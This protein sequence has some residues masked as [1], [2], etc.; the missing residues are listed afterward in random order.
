[1]DDD[2]IY[3]PILNTNLV[4]SITQNT[5][6][7]G[8]NIIHD[9]DLEVIARGV[10]WSTD[11]VPTID[12]NDGMTVDGDGIGIFVSHI[13]GLTEDTQ[14]FICS[15]ATNSE[16][17][18][19]GQV[20]SFVTPALSVPELTTK[21]PIV[22]TLNSATSG[23]YV[24]SSGGMEMFSIGIVW[25]TSGNPTVDSNEGITSNGTELGGFLCEMTGL[26]P[27]THYYIRAYATN[28]YGTGYGNEVSLFI[29]EHA[30]PFL[31]SFVD[32]RDGN[33]YNTVL[34]D[35]ECWMAENLKYLP[36]FIASDN[37]D[38]KYYAY[39]YT[40]YSIAEAQE[41]GN[42]HTYG[43]LYSLDAANNA[44]PSGWHLPGDD[45]WTDL[46]NYLISNGYNYDE[47][48][49][50]NKIAKSMAAQNFWS[51]ATNEGAIGNILLDNN[52]S[53][54]TALPGGEHYFDSFGSL[55]TAGYWWTS[56]QAMSGSHYYRG[57]YFNNDELNRNYEYDSKA[58]SVRCLKNDTL[59]IIHTTIIS[60]LFQTFASSGGNI[61]YSG[62]DDIVSRGIVWSIQ[63]NPTL[64]NNDGFTIDGT[65]SGEFTS[66]L[67]ELLPETTYYVRSYATN[68]V[69]TQYGEQL[70]FISA[71]VASPT[72]TTSEIVD[73]THNSATSGGFVIVVD[74]LNV[75]ARGLVWS[76]Q[77][78]P[79]ILVNEGITVENI[80]TGNFVSLLDGLY[81]STTYYVR[82]YVTL[83][84][85]TAYGQEISF[86]TL[87]FP[88]CGIVEFAGYDYSTILIGNQ[89]WFAENVRYDNGCSSAEFANFTDS[90][91]CGYFNS[92]ESEYG[93]LG[94][95]YQNSVAESICP[96]G[97]HLP[98]H[99]DW[100]ELELSLG[101]S[102][103]VVDDTQFRGTNEGSKLAGN[104]NLWTSN[105][106]TADPE[107]GT[108]GFD[109]LPGGYRDS[110]GDFLNQ[111]TAH[112][113][114]KLGSNIWDNVYR[115]ITGYST[116]IGNF[117]GITNCAFSVRCLKD[118][119]MVDTI[120]T[121][122]TIGLSDVTP[123]SAVFESNVVYDGESD[124]LQK[125]VILG[126]NPGLTI[127][128]VN[129]EITN[130]GNGTGY[131]ESNVTG[132]SPATVYYYRAY[133]IN[134]VGVSYGEENCFGTLVEDAPLQNPCLETPTVMYHG[135]TY[136]TVSIGDQCWMAEN[137]KYLPSVNYES[138]NSNNTP[139]FY[140]Y[141]YSGID[142]VAAQATSNFNTYGVLYNK[143]AM[144]NGGTYSNTNP[145]T[146]QGICPNGWHI[147]SFAEWNQM[148]VYVGGSTVAGGKIKEVATTHWNCPNIGGNNEYGFTALPGGVLENGGSFYYL[149]E[150]GAWWCADATA[151]SSRFSLGYL[152]AGVNQ[153]PLSL[154]GETVAMSVRC[155]R[156]YL[157]PVVETMLI[158]EIA[159]TVATSGGNI[160]SDGGLDI[161]QQGI[162]WSTSEDPTLEN[163]ERIV[164]DTN[165]GS[166]EFICHLDSLIYGTVY[167]VKAFAT[168]SFGISY[169]DQVVFQT[170]PQANLAV[171]ITTPATLI[172]MFSAL[173]GGEVLD[174]GGE[175]QTISGLVWSKLPNPSVDMNDGITQDGFGQTVF[176]S[177]LSEL[178]CDQTYYYKA[179]AI[180]TGG[181]S[182]GQELSFNTDGVSDC[183]P[184]FYNGY[185]YRTVQIGCQCWL[186]ENLRYLPTVKPVSISASLTVPA[187]YV[188]GYSGYNVDEAKETEAYI[189]YGAAYNN[190]AAQNYCPSG[191]KLPS[192]DDW[193]TLEL[194]LGVPE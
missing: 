169:G 123:N 176:T 67:S 180:N 184:V 38:A 139:R 113:S 128:S 153:I 61:E 105:D 98:S 60:D 39:G 122:I 171:V 19:Y 159:Q 63:Q 3:V 79:D 65:G 68:S 6:Q 187:C 44:C 81:P 193:K 103:D 147:P 11:S 18:A 85:G 175:P 28:S 12:L 70:D 124:V 131:Y 92:N 194:F 104:A 174:D 66:F 143:L 83:N 64:E 10:V 96:I 74:D 119:N 55:G 99:N 141:G 5:A 170:N 32:E 155:V 8:G 84:Q 160:I 7:S 42:Y 144:L 115:L 163:C 51:T 108:S 117:G 33:L 24:T 40:G 120:P 15:Y 94:L 110:Y 17:T 58:M 29:N 25:N 37:Y 16:G 157:Y 151:S 13:T 177:E 152:S 134:S 188:H 132:L 93:N 86:E 162:V 145:S 185:S 59:P 191:W 149:N 116:Q 95:L 23:G 46:S 186:A 1:M 45:E 49:V 71:I 56:N 154:G 161:I 26:V 34:V 179:Y 47:S 52:Q 2:E 166:S 78:N 182:Y 189:I 156:D 80:G 129:I 9:G 146:L 88:N 77:P 102:S 133:A 148:V 181:I 140:V 173:S 53:G 158:S 150:Y 142:T 127:N 27:A 43:V 136:N 31:T 54:F 35:D 190:F 20:L 87:E 101:M 106:L 121:V 107:F 75:I 100:K 89:C 36:W 168:N 111:Q 4:D 14:Y 73:L 135:Y 90:G 97:W 48:T 112:F 126:V 137:L 109:A 125:G 167:Y 178:I 69:G 21:Q 72:I 172:E 192:N 41:T 82:A 164:L 138:T 165:L 57:L 62:G 118:Q 91:W 30:C 50:G 76:T 183:S 114:V 130:Q 22:T